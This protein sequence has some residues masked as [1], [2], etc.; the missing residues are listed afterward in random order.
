M[1]PLLAVFGSRT[2]HGH[3][4]HLKASFTIGKNDCHSKTKREQISFTGIVMFFL[5]YCYEKA[6]SHSYC[7]QRWSIIWINFHCDGGTWRWKLFQETNFRS[8]ILVCAGLIISAMLLLMV[9]NQVRPIQ[10]LPQLSCSGM[11]LAFRDPCP[12]ESLWCWLGDSPNHQPLNA[13]SVCDSYKHAVCK[14]YPRK[15]L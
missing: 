12:Q 5:F 1:G 11:Y 13:K 8:I 4:I 14:Y 10:V 9:L 3:P 7:S 6:P 15:Y 2:K